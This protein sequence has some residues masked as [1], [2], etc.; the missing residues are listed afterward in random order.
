ML[1]TDKQMA[2][3]YLRYTLLRC[4]EYTQNRTHAEELAVYILTAACILAKDPEYSNDQPTE[5]IDR[6]VRVIC[7]DRIEPKQAD[8]ET[9]LPD[10]KMQKLAAAMNKLDGLSRQVLTL[11]HLEGMNTKEISQIYN[12][13]IPETR[14]AIINGEKELATNFAQLWPQG[15]DLSE[16]DA[17][18]W[19][20][21]LA[22]ALGL[23]QKI[24]MTEAVEN[25]LA[26]PKKTR[27]LL[28]KY[29]DAI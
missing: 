23:G 20:N 6:L 19:L 5:L 24:R 22:L 28:Q 25:Y 8:A 15:S 27:N 9:L 14:T 11:Y 4:S 16:D 18:L 2:K 17:C 3:Y 7:L 1:S 26:E 13:S 29:L 10:E 21:E 12:N